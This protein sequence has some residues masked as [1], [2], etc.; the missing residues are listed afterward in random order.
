[1]LKIKKHQDMPGIKKKNI[2]PSM[3]LKISIISPHICKSHFQCA[4]F[5]WSLS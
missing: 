3:L 1:L 2:P 4:P 5:L